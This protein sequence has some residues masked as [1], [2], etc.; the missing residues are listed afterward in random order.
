VEYDPQ[1]HRVCVI[2]DRNLSGG[3]SHEEQAQRLLDG[4]ANFIQLRDKEMTS[5]E[6]HET[7]EGIRRLTI[8]Y[9]ALF[10]INDRVDIAAAVDADGVHLGRNDLPVNEARR[11]LGPGALIGASVR[12]PEHARAAADAG[13]DYLGVGPVFEARATKPD[14]PG[15]RGV[16]LVTMICESCNLPV[17][18]IGGIDAENAAEPIL[19][20]ASGVAVISAV[21]GSSDMALA[22]RAIQVAVARAS[23]EEG[24]R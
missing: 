14:A 1:L 4:G 18:A 20:G 15:P 21:V 10:M 3:M 6:L 5:A 12:E 22:V 13:A 16:E 11:F 24:R 17:I 8:E 23:A 19:A 2:T 7:A 9:G